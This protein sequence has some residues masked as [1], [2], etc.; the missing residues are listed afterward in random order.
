MPASWSQSA[1]NGVTVHFVVPEEASLPWQSV[2]DTAVACSLAE[3]E[4]FCK[5]AG[6][7]ARIMSEAEWQR[8]ADCSAGDR[9]GWQGGERNTLGSSGSNQ[10]WLL[11]L[12]SEL[13]LK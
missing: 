7:G 4:A 9:C 3:A 12:D 10:E 8:I 1:S 6:G 11:L 13:C 2:A 5:W